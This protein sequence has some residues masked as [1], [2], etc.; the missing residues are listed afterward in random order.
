MEKRSDEKHE[1]R[2]LTRRDFL[3][4]SAASAA[5]LTLLPRAVMG[6]EG[7]T[8]PSDRITLA[9]IGVGAQ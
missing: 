8:P 9:C 7:A 4:G 3:G 5:A 6:G 1:A 2:R